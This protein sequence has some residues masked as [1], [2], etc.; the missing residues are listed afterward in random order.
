MGRDIYRQITL[1][2]VL[3]MILLG[4]IPV[5]A[6]ENQADFRRELTEEERAYLD[7][8]GPLKVGFVGD[9]IPVS[10]ADSQ[11]NLAGITRYILDRIAQISGLT[12]EY[13]AL[14]AGD[15]TYTYLLEGDFDLVTSVEYN[16]ENQTARG[17]L[18]SDPYLISRKVMVT[19][20]D[21]SASL[22]D[23]LT[24]AICTGSQTIKKVLTGRYPN[25]RMVDYDSIEAGLDAVSRGE[26]DLMIHNQYV[27]E[28]WLYKPVY[29]GLKVIPV[30]DMEDMLCFSAVVPFDSQGQA[31]DTGEG[32]LIQILDKAIARL[33]EDEVSACTIQGVMENQYVYDMGDVLYRYRYAFTVLAVSAVCIVTLLLL[34]S[35]QHM[36][37]MEARADARAKRQFLSTMSHELRTPL[38]GLI[39]LNYLMSRKLGDK[40]QLADYLQQSTATAR[41]LLS[42]VNDILDMSGLQDE[43]VRLVQEPVDVNF[44][45]ST[46]ESIARIGMEEKKLDFSAD[47]QI[48]CPVILGDESRIQQVILNLLDN[49]RKFTPEGGRVELRVRQSQDGEGMIWTR[50]EISD[51]GRGISEEF[52]AQIFG[53]F[54]RGQD[55]VSKGNQGAGLGLPISR[56]LAQLMGGE[57]TFTSKKGEGSEFVFTFP[58]PRAV[59]SAPERGDEARDGRETDREP[60]KDLP[61]ESGLGETEV[62]RKRPRILVAEDNELNGEIML[63]LLE[64]SGFEADLARDG[65]A[66]LELF[67]RSKPGFY[68]VIL[69]DILMPKRNGFETA[70]AIRALQRPDAGTVRIVACSANSDREDRETAMRS[71][72]DGFLSK[73]I[74]LEKLLKECGEA[75]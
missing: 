73:P 4:G 3:G 63:G 75:R 32:M 64:S 29:E 35:R 44:L 53:S 20:D 5:R 17:I 60:V 59:Q 37:S 24:V 71:G 16:R 21:F 1:W 68:G 65:E 28:Y 46:V 33:T 31:V 25:F 51:T 39:G 6:A 36:R 7:G 19:R 47:T 57:L 34:L 23:P 54:N 66:A 40:E 27:A 48:L 13:V 22:D 8:C 67:A 58:A 10:F 2:L 50:V 55:T 45:L 41:Y 15:V 70:A 52:S 43:A 38:N 9:Q 74:N 42:L 14:P 72:M 12:F 26:A 18:I 49:A 69:M 62:I 56:R 30:L 61:E 11:G